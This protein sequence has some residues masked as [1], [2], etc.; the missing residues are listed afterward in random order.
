MNE[1]LLS[2]GPEDMG[3]DEHRIASGYRKG[4]GMAVGACAPIA[5]VAY[6]A[7]VKW[8]LVVGVAEILWAI[9]NVEGRL[10]DLCIRMRRTNLL[11]RDRS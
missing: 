1:P 4:W 3:E 2:V 7:D 9:S 6:F 11:L 10:Y 5:I 8:V